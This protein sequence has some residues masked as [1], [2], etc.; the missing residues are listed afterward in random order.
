[1]AF[2]SDQSSRSLDPVLDMFIRTRRE[3]TVVKQMAQGVVNTF[4][5]RNMSANVVMQMLDTLRYAL[6]IFAQARQTPG[7][8]QLAQDL[9]NDPTLDIVT[10][11]TNMETECR[12][13]RDWLLSVFPVDVNGYLLKEQFDPDGSRSVRSFTP[14][15]LQPLF[16]RLNTLAATID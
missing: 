9:Y 5:T 7:I 11:F 3:A 2:P 8:A 12:S 6:D 15:Q 10:L 4:S 16:T 14:A 1:M 13:V